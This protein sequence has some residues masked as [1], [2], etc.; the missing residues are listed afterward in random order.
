M[1]FKV[2]VETKEI[3]AE[4]MGPAQKKAE[5]TMLM[6]ANRKKIQEEG[7]DDDDDDEEQSMKL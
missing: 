3:E 4:N 6:E 7:G 5:A 1:A 2:K